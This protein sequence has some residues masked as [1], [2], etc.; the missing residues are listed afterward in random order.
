[1]QKTG[2]PTQA[3]N[4]L[5]R[6]STFIGIRGFNSLLSLF[7]FGDCPEFFFT[8]GTSSAFLWIDD[9]LGI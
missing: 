9:E 1:M 4:R 5:D 3:L 8:R 7:F 2:H 6:S